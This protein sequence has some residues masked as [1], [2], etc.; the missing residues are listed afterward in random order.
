MID[1]QERQALLFLAGVEGIGTVK[2][3]SLL[4]WREQ[5]SISLCEVVDCPTL[6]PV[7]QRLPKV[8]EKITHFK[9]V[10]LL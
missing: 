4:D 2:L 6:S 8:L 10:F 7:L 3:R 1:A 9:E 5:T